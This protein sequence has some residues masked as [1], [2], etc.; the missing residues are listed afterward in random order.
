MTSCERQSPRIH[1]T[2]CVVILSHKSSTASSPLFVEIIGTILEIF[3]FQ[4]K[5]PAHLVLES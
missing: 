3:C 5:F 1:A 2:P 4:R